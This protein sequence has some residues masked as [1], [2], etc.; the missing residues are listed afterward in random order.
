M[1]TVFSATKI[2][3]MDHNL[4]EATHVAVRDGLV[5]AVG[6]PDC[7]A[8]WGE[9]RLD[10]RFAECVLMPGLIEAHAHVMAGGI[11]RFCYVGHYPR[12]VADGGVSPAATTYDAI[13]ERLRM[14]AASITPDTPVVGW[15][16]DPA[17]VE[18]PRLDRHALD[19]VSTAHPV[20]VLH[21][22][23]HLLTANTRAL[24]RAGMEPLA[25]IEGACRAPDGTLSGE[26]Q[27][28]KAMLPVMKLAGIEFS[29]ISDERAL[30]DYARL[31]RTCGVTTIADLNSDLFNDEVEM[32]L[33]VTSESA[34]P[35]RYAPVMAA[36]D[37]EPEEAAA[38]ALALR[39]RS[40]PKLHLGSAKLFTDGAIQGRTAK[41]KPPGYLT[42]PDNGIWNMDM[43]DFRRS[44]HVLHRSGVKIHVHAN[45]DEATE[46]SILAFE[47]AMLDSPNPD[48]R[49]TLEHAQLAGI[50]Q[51]KRMRA[52]GLTVNLFANHMHYFGDIH[53]TASL[54]PDRARR[55]NACADAWRIFDGDFA[56]HS[57]APVTPLAPMKTAWCAVNRLTR[58]GRRLGDSQRLT[59]AQALR[60]ITLGAAH[61]LK[62]DDRVGS[63]QCGKHA[64]FCVLGEDPLAVDPSDLADVPIIATVLAGEVTP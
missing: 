55:M 52:L 3:T 16:F 20:V 49:H 24:E 31:A 34:F 13:L 21:S 36:T 9:S 26:L 57:D 64:D 19:R 8:G 42:G 2:I 38:R 23:L 6:G 29:D 5:L 11:S 1:I 40:T 43:E 63:I 27:E 59:V 45:G 50:D 30:R 7:A 48:L 47:A 28:F 53:W 37:V 62:L 46:Q 10:N 18:G 51:F 17:F 35:V 14:A 56:I 15:G 54:G 39:P 44:V 12:A 4:P 60:C 32:L 25:A 41:L 58:S 61:V 33:R 22:N